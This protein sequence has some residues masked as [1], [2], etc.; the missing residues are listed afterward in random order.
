[1]PP[2]AAAQK[3]SR[4]AAAQLE[5]SPPP[6]DARVLEFGEPSKPRTPVKVT[7]GRRRRGLSSP[8]KSSDSSPG[9]RKNVVKRARPSLSALVSPSGATGGRA[10]SPIVLSDEEA[11]GDER[12]VPK[13]PLRAKT[14]S[15]KA[16]GSRH[17]PP[18]KKPSATVRRKGKSRAASNT[19]TPSK[20]KRAI[21]ISS[22]SS[23][24]DLSDSD[25]TPLS[26]PSPESAMP[27][28]PTRAR[29]A[30]T[31]T[32]LTSSQVSKSVISLRRT[33]SVATLGESS[34]ADDE[35]WSLSKLGTLVWV[36]VDGAGEVVIES[37]ADYDGDAYWWPAKVVNLKDPLKVTLLG[38]GPHLTDIAERDGLI[39]ASPSASNILSMLSH[40]GKVRFSEENYKTAIGATAAATSARSPRKRRKLDI[41]TRWKEARE[42]ML[43]EDED[44]NEGLPV[45]L[46]SHFS[47]DASFSVKAPSASG[48]KPIEEIILSDDDDLPGPRE[49]RWRPPP[50]D[51]NLEIPGELVLAKEKKM[52]TE[53][54]PAKLLE[55][56][57]PTHPRQRPRYKALFYDG[58]IKNIDA[59]WFFSVWDNKNL[60]KCKLGRDLYDYG[61]EEERDDI[62]APLHN[63]ASDTE[64]L[65][66]TLRVPTP[67]PATPPPESFEDL[68]LTEQFDYVKPV[69]MAVIEGRFVPANERHD[70]FMRGATARRLVCE[71]GYTRGSL[72]QDEVEELLHLIRHW[73]ARRERRRELGIL[74]GDRTMEPRIMESGACVESSQSLQAPS[75]DI[76]VKQTVTPEAQPAESQTEHAISEAEG[77]PPSQLTLDTDADAHEPPFPG[78]STA[79][80]P[81]VGLFQKTM[82]AYQLSPL[83]IARP[84]RSDG[85][86]VVS[87]PERTALASDPARG[88]PLLSEREGSSPPNGRQRPRPKLSFKDLSAIDQITYCQNIL[89]HEAVLQLLLWRS[90]ER[91]SPGLLTDQEEKRLHD[92]AFEKAN[93]NDW[94]HEI[95]RLKQAAEGKM[96][97][98]ANNDKSNASAAPPASSGSTRTRRKRG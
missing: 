51:L 28:P 3:A 68:S 82:Y 96:L 45:L 74:V 42:L 34:V 48:G 98:W 39:V 4:L 26:S 14:V 53:Y 29:S 72:R 66:D 65:D 54:W 60:V 20:R 47:R 69:L 75:A 83:Q 31:L 90:G 84:P 77:P 13:S 59:D 80:P 67:E 32:T 9:K 15:R 10:E 22:N 49:K 44:A 94:V 55:Y 56:I 79:M 27:P 37:G 71:S 7:Y 61:L 92:I 33:H 5:S 63:E 21:S 30:S 18:A 19:T 38:D 57:P 12:D 6:S 40:R 91:T 93:E 16:G 43:Q 64:I 95:I 97:P 17:V 88:E 86:E 8:I 89:L 36:R 73:A 58:I 81:S 11:E 87:S 76:A 50:R 35:P 70:N 78:A 25:L 1:M 52:Y 41:D 85:H 46:S 2:R 62:N 24:S 23:L